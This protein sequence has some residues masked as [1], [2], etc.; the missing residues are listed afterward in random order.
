MI[1]LGQFTLIKLV[2]RSLLYRSDSL[3]ARAILGT[4]DALVDLSRT[5]KIYQTRAANSN[6][7]IYFRR[8]WLTLNALY[9][10]PKFHYNA[11]R[12]KRVL[13]KRFSITS[14]IELSF[15]IDERHKSFYHSIAYQSSHT[16]CVANFMSI[17]FTFARVL[18]IPWMYLNA[19]L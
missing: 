7:F 3:L 8:S 19:I 13:R 15:R 14:A 5:P 9:R 11:E 4:N 6:A 1:G 18:P 12:K 17:Y 16:N 10:I 2:S